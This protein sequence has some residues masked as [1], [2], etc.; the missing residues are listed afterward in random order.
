M[1]SF[2]DF[3]RGESK[4]VSRV[5]KQETI[6]KFL[7]LYSLRLNL[8]SQSYQNENWKTGKIYGFHS[9]SKINDPVLWRRLRL[10]SRTRVWGWQTQKHNNSRFFTKKHSVLIKLFL[11]WKKANI[12]L[13]SET[14]F[15]KI[16]NINS[17]RSLHLLINTALPCIQA[18]FVASPV[19]KLLEA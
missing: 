18:Q 13:K 5:T 2:Q 15:H 16:L 14:I 4:D 10:I 1:R 12:Q 17:S 7:S 19:S 6:L 9:R 8:I 11:W 3:K